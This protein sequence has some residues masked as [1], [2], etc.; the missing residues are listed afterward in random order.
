MCTMIRSLGRNNRDCI[1]NN[2]CVRKI[3][4]LFMSLVIIIRVSSSRQ[5]RTRNF[6]IIS[7]RISLS[8]GLS[9]THII[10]TSHILSISLS[11]GESGCQ[12]LVHHTDINFRLHIGIHINLMINMWIRTRSILK[13]RLRANISHRDRARIHVCLR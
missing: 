9:L 10:I 11:M 4:R 12:S 13:M 6:L 1:N 5:I 8:R 7:C 3:Q 2:R